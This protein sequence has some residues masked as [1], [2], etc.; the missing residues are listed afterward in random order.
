MRLCQT[1]LIYRR[2]ADVSR[3]KNLL[4]KLLL[5]G[6]VCERE[7]GNE[8]ECVWVC[9]CVCER[10]WKRVWV[11]VSVCVCLWERENVWIETQSGLF[12]PLSRCFWIYILIWSETK[13]IRRK[14]WVEIT[15][16]TSRSEQTLSKLTMTL[17]K[18]LT[19]IFCTPYDRFK[20]L[21]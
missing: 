3:P 2:C 15:H 10:E 13:M 8:C 6:C 5:H 19:K 9:V 1:D 7:S 17:K 20:D 12:P 4:I 16:K 14:L 18:S 21:L 11:C